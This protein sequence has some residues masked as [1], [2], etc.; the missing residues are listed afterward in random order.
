[1]P[2]H[3]ATRIRRPYRE[4]A[5]TG[6]GA[7]LIVA[8][9]SLW[10]C[11]AEPDGSVRDDTG[12]SRTAD[13]ANAIVL[14]EVP[15]DT[16]FGLVWIEVTVNGSA[17]LPFLLDTG[18]D[19]SVIDAGIAA[20]LSLAVSNP[21]TVPQPG[22]AVELGLAEGV[23]IGVPGG[24]FHDWTLRAIPI[25]AASRIVGREFSGILGHDV[26]A[27]RVWRIDY[28]AGTLTVYDPSS[29]LPVGG[30]ELAVEV[31]AA[32]PFIEA[33]IEQPHA[34]S[35]PGRFKLDTG[36]TDV[37]GLNLNFHE[38]AGVLAPNQATIPVPGVAVGG[39]TTGIL[40][41][42]GAFRIG[43]FSISSP[44]IG[45]TLESAGFEN[46]AD[47][48]TIG[49][50]ALRQFTLTLD[51]PHDRILLEPNSSY[52]TP[53]GEDLSGLWPVVNG[54]DFSTAR[55]WFVVPDGPAERAG[56]QVDDLI[57]AV[58]G[59]PVSELRL[60]GVF[61][62]MRTGAGATRVLRIDRGG[63]ILELPVRLEPLL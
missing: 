10:A 6:S 53:A 20:D 38:G 32:E 50:G 14:A 47:A 8:A 23:S 46:R 22:G 49:G 57:L 11:S 13:S 27:E 40:Y 31:I 36:S 9:I 35:I 39:E 25:A 51:Y 34:G 16:D 56:V 3:P 19:Y 54:E 45:A 60:S 2:G 12:V 28:E 4:R 52:G 29:V 48:G 37:A 42:I 63:E 21:D 7:L 18:F 61:E 30:A 43:P 17:P 24:E 33:A 44:V 55:V 5:R 1:M 41:R 62:L 15:I 58:D 59:V 26:L